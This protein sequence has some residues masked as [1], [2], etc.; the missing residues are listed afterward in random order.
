MNSLVVSILSFLL[1][2]KYSALFIL[3][4]VC[5]FIIPLPSNVIVLV[6]GVFISQG[7]FSFWPSLIIASVAGTLGDSF[8]YWL[9]K[10]Y[11]TRII[12][13]FWRRRRPAFLDRTEK[14]LTRSAGLTIVISRFTGSLGLIINLLAGLA[15]VKFKRFLAFD[16]IGNILNVLFL[17]TLGYWLGVY[18]QK[19]ADTINDVGLLLTAAIIVFIIFQVR[20]KRRNRI[21]D[22]KSGQKA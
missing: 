17:F 19:A 2:Y 1:L 7:Y 5:T 3:S 22:K 18:W 6:T 4:F 14:Y 8:G 11:G 15:P 9:A 16:F 20:R 13:F 21:I 12:N 10:K